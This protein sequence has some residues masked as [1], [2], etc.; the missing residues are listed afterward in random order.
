MAEKLNNIFDSTLSPKDKRRNGILRFSHNPHTNPLLSH[1]ALTAS[2][3][4]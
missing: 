2:V 3:L 4:R 1:S